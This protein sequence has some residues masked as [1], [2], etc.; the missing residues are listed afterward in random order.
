[1]TTQE[2]HWREPRPI[3]EFVWMDLEEWDGESI[4]RYGRVSWSRALGGPYSV[5]MHYEREHGLGLYCWPRFRAL[6]DAQ[7]F[8]ERLWQLPLEDVRA[9]HGTQ[10][11]TVLL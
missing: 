4:V 10:W 8:V 2:L 5:Q 6:S 1:M 11:R 9:L 7:D 3:D